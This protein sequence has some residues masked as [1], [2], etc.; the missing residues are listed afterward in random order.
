MINRLAIRQSHPQ[1]T[2]YYYGILN[3]EN[4]YEVTY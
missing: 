4:V 3:K 1:A 2:R